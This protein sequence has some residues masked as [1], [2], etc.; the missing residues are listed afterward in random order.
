M[1]KDITLAE[2]RRKQKEEGVAVVDVR[3]PSE[4]EDAKIPGSINIPVFN[5]EERAEVG[6][7]YKKVGPEAAKMRGIEIIS[8]KLPNFIREFEKIKGEKIVYC[9]RG[10]MRS[11]IAATMIDLAGTDAYRLIGG[12]R[13]YRN[14]VTET[15]ENMK[16]NPTFYVLNGYTGIGKTKILQHLKEEGYPVIDFEKMAQHR[17]SIFGHVGLKPNNQKA[18][19][20]L[21][22]EELLKYKDEPFILVEGESKRIGKVVIPD[23]ILKKKAEGIQLYLEM[24]IQERVKHIIEDY[25]P[26]NYKEN[27]LE[28]FHI[29]KKHIH[30]PIAKEIEECLLQDDFHTAVELLLQYY[31]DP[32]YN[33]SIKHYANGDP[34]VIQAKN[35]ND[36]ANQ[37]KNLL[38]KHPIA[39]S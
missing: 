14:W 10:G 38:A 13:T 7:L 16:V 25:E 15:L 19:D 2:L 3:S 35:S 39:L 31:Y 33:H 26:W 9:W 4:H 12:F 30:T 18:F 1:F 17:G 22:V 21:L 11:K 23:E 29:I 32:R 24:P 6:T 27:C 20:S 5:D 36:A 37:I 28:A 8:Q 34:I